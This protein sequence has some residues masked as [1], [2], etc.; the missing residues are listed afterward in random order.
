MKK[1][2]IESV[3]CAYGMPVHVNPKD[4]VEPEIREKVK[5]RVKDVII[6]GLATT[7]QNPSPSPKVSQLK[8][9]LMAHPAPRIYNLDGNKCWYRVKDSKFVRCRLEKSGYV[10]LS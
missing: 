5:R 8:S 3:K 7:T 10:R 1:Q 9:V 2:L 6:A 4:F